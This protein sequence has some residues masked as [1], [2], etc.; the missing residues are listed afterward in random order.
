[1]LEAGARASDCAAPRV[2]RTVCNV[3]KSASAAAGI[4]NHGQMAG[5]RSAAEE[6]GRLS[7]MARSLPRVQRAGNGL[8]HDSK[9]ADQLRSGSGQCPYI[10]I[11]CALPRAVAFAYEEMIVAVASAGTLSLAA[12][13]AY[14]R[15]K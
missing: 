8:L 11:S 1:M 2:W 5:R 7:D 3:Q 15:K 6:R 12:G 13:M 9:P 10:P 4:A 14:S